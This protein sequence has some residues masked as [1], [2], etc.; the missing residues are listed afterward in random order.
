MK[1]LN[2]PEQAFVP[3]NQPQPDQFPRFYI[4]PETKYVPRRQRASNVHRYHQPP[5]PTPI[6]PSTETA[7]RKYAR[8]EIEI[9][10][11]FCR[12]TWTAIK[13]LGRDL[14]QW[15]ARWVIMPLSVA[16]VLHV[17]TIHPMDL[18]I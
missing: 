11:K 9:F 10:Q 14:T 13:E 12:D 3:V 15:I 1:I 17:P 7:F 2:K 16:S 6:S 5:C 8:I 4:I 18:P